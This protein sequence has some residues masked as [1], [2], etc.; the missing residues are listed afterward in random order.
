[1]AIST[2]VQKGTW[3]Y[4]YDEKNHQLFSK[5]GELTGFTSNSVSIKRTGWIYI[6]DEKGHQTGSHHA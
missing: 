2:A 6:Y 5:T 3:V 4:V 1:M